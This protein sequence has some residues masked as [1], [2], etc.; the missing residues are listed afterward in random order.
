MFEEFVLTSKN[1]IRTVT[2]VQV[3]FPAARLVG[4]RCCRR[5]HVPIV[6]ILANQC[7]RRT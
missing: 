2:G 3:R 7:A 4:C 6:D 1:Y 5:I